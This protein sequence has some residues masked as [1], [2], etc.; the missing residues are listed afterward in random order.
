MTERVLITGAGG[1]IGGRLVEVMHA[2][3]VAAVRAAVRRWSTAA[4]V[5][6][7]PVDI[8]QCDIAQRTDVDRAMADVTSVVHCARG[9]PELNATGTRNVLEASLAAGVRRVVHLSTIEVYGAAD[10]EVDESWPLRATGSPYG[11]SKIEA[12]KLCI[13][14]RARGLDVVVLR[15]AVV[16]GP[17]SG[18]WTIEFA[19]RFRSGA[20]F[21]PAR[22][23]EGTCNLVY[24]DDLV[25][26]VL[27][28]LRSN[29]AAGEAFNVNGAECV[30]WNEYFEALNTAVGL[31]PL[32]RSGRVTAHL[33]A[34]ALL[35]VR[36]TAKLL[37]RHFEPQI[38]AVYRRFA[39]ARRFAR[40][41]EG[42]I[43]R[44]P[45]PEEFTL[46]GRRAFYPTTKAERILGYRPAFPMREGIALSA[47]WLRH[48]RFV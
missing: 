7:L 44:T 29:G 28:A 14:Y 11:D 33:S 17:F 31:P 3:R 38:L 35:P 26:A 37:L 32:T 18:S 24:V 43:R 25:A 45:T 34:R 1:F 40:G 4:R 36:K 23:C 30:T 9:S 27:L 10:G 41:I 22:Y 19:Q 8:V 21:L 39:V 13:A 12:E 5:G 6:R 46:Y 47:Q 15:P 2:G 42:A 16:Y 20:P 48:H